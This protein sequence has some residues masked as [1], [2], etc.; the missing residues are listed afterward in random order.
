MNR[1]NDS[2][3]SLST[4][5]VNTLQTHTAFSLLCKFKWEIYAKHFAAC[6]CCVN[7][8]H[9]HTAKTLLRSELCCSNSIKQ[10]WLFPSLSTI[11]HALLHLQPNIPHRTKNPHFL[12]GIMRSFELSMRMKDEEVKNW[13]SKRFGKAE[14]YRNSRTMKMSQISFAMHKKMIAL[15]E[16]RGTA[17]LFAPDNISLRLNVS[18]E[19]A[20]TCT[21]VGSEV[22][23]SQYLSLSARVWIWL[24]D[25]TF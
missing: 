14:I 6:C 11:P 5:H 25:R 22:C 2:N 17:C 7:A 4:Q 10:Y 23:S 24:I 20:A 1:N 9:G 12:F 15:W 3:S 19:L 18:R 21:W 13:L 16:G 8:D